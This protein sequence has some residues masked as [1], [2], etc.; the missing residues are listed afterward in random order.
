MLLENFPSSVLNSSIDSGTNGVYINLDISPFLS[1]L[2][3][4][5]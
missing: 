5:C 3:S 1:S 2:K 4:S